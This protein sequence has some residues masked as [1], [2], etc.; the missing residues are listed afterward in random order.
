MR[1]LGRVTIAHAREPVD[2]DMSPS[3]IAAR[4]RPAGKIAMRV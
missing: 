2:K 3:R 4:W 1:G